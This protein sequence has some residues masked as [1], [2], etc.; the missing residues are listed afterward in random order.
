MFFQVES[1]PEA[2]PLPPSRQY[3][4]S[5]VSEGKPLTTKSLITWNSYFMFSL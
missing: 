1:I 5:K 3:Q 4:I 2:Y